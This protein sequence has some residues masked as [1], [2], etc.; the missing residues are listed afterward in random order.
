M[1]CRCAQYPPQYYIIIEEA[2]GCTQGWASQAKNLILQITIF[3]LLS[4]TS[5]IL[6][7]ASLSNLV[8]ERKKAK[9]A[10]LRQF[11]GQSECDFVGLRC[12]L[13]SYYN[14][15]GIRSDSDS[16]SDSRK[17]LEETCPLML[18]REKCIY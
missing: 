9:Q 1:Y 11:F 12:E 3:A 15:T 14:E 10:E 7:F 4:G 8:L 13:F 5:T 2:I 6:L 17:L 18:F 16:D